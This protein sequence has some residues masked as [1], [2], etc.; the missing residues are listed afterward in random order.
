MQSLATVTSAAV[1][2]V[3]FGRENEIPPA[4]AA[5]ARRSD[6]AVIKA[7]CFMCYPFEVNLISKYLNY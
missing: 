1:G 5:E 7:I 6:V 3:K 4:V 2:N